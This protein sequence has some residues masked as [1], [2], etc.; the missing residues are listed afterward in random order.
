MPIKPSGV[1]IYDTS[2]DYKMERISHGDGYYGPNLLDGTNAK[3]S[4]NRLT[5][6]PSLEE[7]NLVYCKY[8]NLGCSSIVKLDVKR[9]T[10]LRILILRVTRIQVLQTEYLVNLVY[11]NI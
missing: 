6:Y 3:F 11:L 9:L 4:V 7:K 10:S 2:E 8:L 1:G 5:K